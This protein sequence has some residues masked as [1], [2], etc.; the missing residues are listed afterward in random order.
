MPIIHAPSLEIAAHHDFDVTVEM[1]YGSHVVEGNQFTAAHHQSE[2]PYKGVHLGGTAPAPCNNDAIPNVGNGVIGISHVDLDTLGGVLRAT[3]KTE[4]FI[5]KY[6]SFWQLAEFVD[7]NGPHRLAQACASKNDEAR[8]FAFWAWSQKNRAPIS[9]DDITDVTSYFETAAA[10]LMSCLRLE[11]AYLQAGY[12]FKDSS[13]KLNK[14]SFVEHSD[15]IVVRVAPSFVNHLYADPDGTPARCVVAYNTMT[16][17]CTISFADPPEGRTAKE[18]VQSIWGDEAGGHA[19]IAG[20]PRGM[21]MT[22][23]DL[24]RL[25]AE[26]VQD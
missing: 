6:K 14:E 25:A 17:A 24:Y 10:A 20:S 18:I 8:I 13:D 21:R 26:A 5:P 2:G 19:S 22:L 3:G 9:R 7:V 4:F 15:G 16:G 1:E 11:E 12:D 23:T